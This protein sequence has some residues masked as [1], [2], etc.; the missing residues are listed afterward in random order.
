M[1]NEHVMWMCG[2][3][4]DMRNEHEMWMCRVMKDEE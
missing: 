3:M 4:K 2:V 1:R